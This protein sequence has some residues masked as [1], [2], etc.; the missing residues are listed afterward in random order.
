MGWNMRNLATQFGAPRA[1]LG[2]AAYLFAAQPTRHVI[3]L[4]ADASGNSTGIV[5]EGYCGTD[6]VWHFKNLMNEAQ[7]APPAMSSAAPTA[8]AFEAEQTQHVLYRASDNHIH[9]LYWNGSWNHNDLTNNTGAPNISGQAY[10]WEF[11]TGGRQQVVF[12][13]ADNLVHLL[14]RGYA[15]NPQWQHQAL[16]TA[17]DPL[18]A[19]S[20]GGYPFEAARSQHVN[21]RSDDSGDLRLYEIVQDPN[22]GKWGTPIDMGKGLT[23]VPQVIDDQ[24]RGFADEGSGVRYVNFLGDDYSIYEY[25]FTG[26]WNLT[27]LTQSCVPPAPLA[28]AGFRP[29]PYMFASSATVPAATQHSIYIGANQIQELWRYAGQTWNENALSG[30]FDEMLSNS[31]SAFVDTTASTQNVFFATSAGEIIELRWE[32][33]ETIIFHPPGRQ[34]HARRR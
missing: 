7:G 13:G 14:T 3:Y 27:N 16:A 6:D 10:G 33:G 2:P 25:S 24:H 34:K 12:M 1:C 8:F 17:G 9:E 15:G 31:P 11:V 21:Y 23:G 19:V 4:G 30:V 29:A 20:P 18:C 5:Y 28:Y 26:S 32:V 22:T